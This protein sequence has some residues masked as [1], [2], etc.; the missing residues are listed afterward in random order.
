MMKSAHIQRYHPIDVAE[1]RAQEASEQPVRNRPDHVRLD[2][3]GEGARSIRSRRSLN[4]FRFL[5][6]YV[7]RQAP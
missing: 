3:V 7:K 1:K 6:D 2:G 4:E 5:N